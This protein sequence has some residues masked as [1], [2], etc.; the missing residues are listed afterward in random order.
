VKNRGENVKNRRENVKNRGEIVKNR[1]E[2]VKNQGKMPKI[3]LWSYFP[4]PDDVKCLWYIAD[5]PL[6]FGVADVA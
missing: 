5:D 3:S 2:N 6:G 1:G 4:S